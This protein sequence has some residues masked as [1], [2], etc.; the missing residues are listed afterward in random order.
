[1]SASRNQRVALSLLIDDARFAFTCA[2]FEKS[3]YGKSQSLASHLSIRSRLMQFKSSLSRLVEAIKL[4]ETREV[5]IARNGRPVANLIPIEASPVGKRI[6]VA[7]GKFGVPDDID[8]HN[9]ELARLLQ[10][11]KRS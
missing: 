1:M 3:L 11:G 7:K 2:I 9:E 6:S 5:A 8:D 4:D 10:S